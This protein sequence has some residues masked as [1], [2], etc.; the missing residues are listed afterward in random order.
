MAASSVTLIPRAAASSWQLNK[1]L[2]GAPCGVCTDHS[3]LLSRVEIIFPSSTSFIVSD[4]GSP[5]VQAPRV[6]SASMQRRKYSAPTRGRAPS[7]TM[8]KSGA[9][10]LSSIKPR[11]TDACLVAPPSMTLRLTVRLP[12]P[13]SPGDR[14]LFVSIAR[15]SAICRRASSTYSA[16]IVTIISFMP[17]ICLHVCIDHIY[18]GYPSNISNC[19]GRLP[20]K[21]EPLPPAVMTQANRWP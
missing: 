13:L 19:L 8:T 5:I 20:P 16:G 2:N 4:I 3:R 21:R 14:S 11:Y 17:T 1:R 6:V 15:Y 10:C 18:S 9:A 12:W 7:C